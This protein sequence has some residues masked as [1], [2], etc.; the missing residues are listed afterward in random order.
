MS[1]RAEQRRQ[2]KKEA[3]ADRAYNMTAVSLEATLNEAIKR[4]RERVIPKVV[5]DM[6]VAM[7]MVLH[8]KLGFGETRLKRFLSDIMDIYDSIERGYINIAEIEKCLLDET[9]VEIK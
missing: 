8:D 4:E 3:K 5:H 2:Q 9:G 6:N 1:N 7:A